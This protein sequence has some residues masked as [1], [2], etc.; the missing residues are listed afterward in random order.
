MTTAASASVRHSSHLLLIIDAAPNDKTLQYAPAFWKLDAFSADVKRLKYASFHG[1]RA[2]PILALDLTVFDGQGKARFRVGENCPG[3]VIPSWRLRYDA[4]AEQVSDILKRYAESIGANSEGTSA[5]AKRLITD[6][7]TAS[8]FQFMTGTVD[9]AART[10]SYDI[11]RIG[12]LKQPRASSLLRAFTAY[13]S[14]DGFDH[15]LTRT[16]AQAG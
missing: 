7:L 13:L 6:A 15:D 8:V 16:V 12:R 10:V 14:R 5:E 3:N 2:V 1:V 11:E 4:I 9:T